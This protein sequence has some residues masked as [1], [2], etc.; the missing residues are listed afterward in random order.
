MFITSV[1]EQMDSMKFKAAF[2]LGEMN[3]EACGAAMMAQQKN[4]LYW[5]IPFFLY[6]KTH[7]IW[8]RDDVKI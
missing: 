5:H 1:K 3:V 4:N 7:N 8:L 2:F 6:D